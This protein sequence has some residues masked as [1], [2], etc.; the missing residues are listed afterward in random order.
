MSQIRFEDESLEKDLIPPV[1]IKA[2]A[3]FLVLVVILATVARLTGLGTVNTP[4][5]ELEG[6]R[7]VVTER[8]LSFQF[9]RV[10]GPLVLVDGHSGEV[11]ASFDAAD[12]GFIRGAIR[13]LNRER[14]RGGGAPDAPYRLVQWSDGALL[15]EDPLTGTLVDLRAF[16][17]TNAGDFAKLLPERLP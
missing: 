3:V 9:D 8:W 13:P 4:M 7:T 11:L 12:G 15:L 16:G 5:G 1:A 2:V 10:D 6:G 14:V 17:P